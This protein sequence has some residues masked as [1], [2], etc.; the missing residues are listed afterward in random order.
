MERCNTSYLDCSRDAPYKDYLNFIHSLRNLL[1]DFF[2]CCISTI[3]LL[4]ES[5]V[6]NTSPTYV[7]LQYTNFPS[8]RT[9]YAT[10]SIY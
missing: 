4:L 8:R 10:V 3:S 1:L 6:P 9:S 5:Q 7:S 2:D